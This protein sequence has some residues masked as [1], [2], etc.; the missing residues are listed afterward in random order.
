MF[1]GIQI[2]LLRAADYRKEKNDMWNYLNSE[3]TNC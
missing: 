1:L 3:F 2:Y